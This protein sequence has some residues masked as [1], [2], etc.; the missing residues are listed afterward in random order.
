MRGGRQAGRARRDRWTG[1]AQPGRVRAPV[2]GGP[3]L[4]PAD[5]GAASVGGTGTQDGTR[6]SE[7]PARKEDL[8]YLVE[9]ECSRRNVV[10]R[11]R[12]RYALVRALRARRVQRLDRLRVELQ[13]R[14]THDLL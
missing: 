10:A 14:R 8:A 11:P 6:S 9:R 3:R 7:R 1:N 13:R 5:P 2:S 4:S 12:D